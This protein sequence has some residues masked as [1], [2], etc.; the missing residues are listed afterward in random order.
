M[1]SQDRQL[2]IDLN[3]NYPDVLVV[4]GKTLL[5]KSSRK[6]KSSNQKTEKVFAIEVC[7][8]LNSGGGKLR[9]ESEDRNYFWE[10]GICG[11]IEMSLRDCWQKQAS[12][13]LC[14]DAAGE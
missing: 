4:I 7:A 14:M 12:S 8:L 3:T 1:A 9:M 2:L 5:G 6:K 13:I 10:H 11:D